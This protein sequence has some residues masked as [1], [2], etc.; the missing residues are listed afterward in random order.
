MKGKKNVAAILIAC[1]LLTMSSAVLGEETESSEK[2][3][4]LK[5]EQISSGITHT[6]KEI[7]NFGGTAGK[8]QRVNVLEADLTN[9]NVSIVTSK[10]LERVVAA[11]PLPSQ[12]ARE[13]FKGKDIVAGVNADM[14]NMQTGI[15]MTLQVQNRNLLIN[16]SY[17][18]GVSHH[19]VFAIDQDKKPF[20]GEVEMRGS[21]TYSGKNVKIDTLNRSENAGEKLGIFTPKLNQK[22]VLTFDDR[23]ETFI[24][25][26][27]MAVVKKVQ[28]ASA[29]KAGQAYSGKIE[30]IY[31]SYESIDIPS[32]SVI[33]TGFGSK[34]EIIRNELK[35][36]ME[37][38]FQFDL[39]TGQDR[40]LKNDITE[41]TGGYNWLVKDGKALS[42]DELES[43]YG[44]HVLLKS[45]RTA[46][47]ITAEQ[48]VITMTIDKPSTLFDK[49][50]GVTLVEM[51]EIMEEHGAVSALGL[52][53]GGSTEM[54]VQPK[55][56]SAL[57]TA[58]H[59]SDGQSRSITNGILFVNHSSK[60]DD[61]GEVIVEK[62]LTIFKN[63][64]FPFGVK[65]TDSNGNPVMIASRSIKWEASKGTI[66][67]TGLYKAPDQE[68]TDKVQ[69]VINGVSGGASVTVID[70]VD[71]FQFT[72][73]GPI[74]LQPGEEGKLDAEAV[75]DGK[76]VILSGDAIDWEMDQQYGE[77]T[78]DG[79]IQVRED[80]PEG[81]RTTVT[82]KLGSLERQV[83]LLIGLKEQVLDDYE[84][85]PTE[86]YGVTGFMGGTHQLSNEQAKFG[87][88]SLRIDYDS[89]KW[90]RKYN[91]TI[92]VVPHW[93]KSA[94][95]AWSDELADSMYETYKTDIRPKKFGMWVYGD[96][97][98][99]WARLIFKAN[100]VNKTLD[101]APKVD[102]IGWKYLEV[103]LP[104]DWELPIVFN[105]LYFVETSKSIPDYSGSVYLDH[106]R[107]IYSN[108]TEDFNGPEFKEITP[109]GNTVYENKIDFS[110]LLIDEESGVDAE[111]I[112]VKINGEKIPH[113]YDTDTGRVEAAA[114]NLAEGTYH[115]TASARDTNGNLSVPSV[116]KRIEVD[117]SEDN[118]KPV[119]SNVTP[120][121]KAVEKTAEPRITFKLKD[122][123]S[124]VKKSSIAVKIDGRQAPV[125]YD[126][127]SG[128][129]YAVPEKPLKDGQ[130]SFI[131]EAKDKSGNVMTPYVKHFDTKQ[132]QQPKKANQFAISILPDTQGFMYSKRL[133]DRAAKEETDFVM[134]V[135]DMV[136]TSSQSE[137]DRAG[138]DLAL[139]GDKPFFA[140]P[141]NHESFQGNI[142]FYSAIVGSPTYH[143]EYGNTLIISLNSAFGQSISASDPTQFHYL[144]KLLKENKKKNVL[145]V[146]H[147][148]TK[149]DF[150]TK[151]EMNPA[152]AKQFEDILGS[153][154][155]KNKNVNI[156]VLFGH[157]HLLQTWEVDGVNYTIT[158]NGASKGY[159]SNDKGNILGSGILAVTKAGMDYRFNP[160][161]TDVSIIDDALNEKREMKMAAGAKRTLNLFGDFR[162]ISGNYLVNLSSFEE[163]HTV[164]TSDNEKAVKVLADGTIQTIKPGKAN[165]T[166][167]SGGKSS[168]IKVT[169][170]DSLNIKP[171]NVELSPNNEAVI[172]G[173]NIRLTATAIDK[174]GNRFAMD[175]DKLFMELTPPD[176]AE[177]KKGKIKTKKSGTLTISYQYLEIKKSLE[178][179]ILPK[180][181]K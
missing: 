72:D 5:T 130:H 59:P 49:S 111:S 132:L 31:S 35:E 174:D 171:V 113:T 69:A 7:V 1:T 145:V 46:I 32:D 62:D 33:I 90:E 34:A 91:G 175:P 78:A 143:F 160:L 11:E 38:S 120:A 52:D 157:L 4:V 87:E 149:D 61:I 100:N 77:I 151:H 150:G 161:L 68:G 83:E 105:Y 92:N 153:Y 65:A 138:S 102:W 134:H 51:A 42:K 99:P 23:N 27:A 104:Q 110:S 28:D 101:L 8:S 43:K 176:L 66:D 103:E 97:K 54:I 70:Q 84:T 36:G 180:K 22:G 20:I 147:N 73:K 30:K 81:T 6:E 94:S 106:M 170:V 162:E 48:K 117:L 24:K 129:A 50:Q 109:A 88:S 53:G 181:Q 126:E 58:N 178:I 37:I 57:E 39:F 179:E 71:D 158:G 142:D 89:K 16:H 148:T 128:W 140:T 56:K 144:Q 172:E 116:D 67:K 167:V 141:G 146:T 64:S 107:Y 169:V 18:S 95:G 119:L 154:K 136:D 74:I 166:A 82:A 76:D 60:T 98:A 85:F 3:R 17:P 96:G 155:K 21:L 55:G 44:S 80:V 108:E 133:F 40:V 173:K 10:A 118:E 79:T 139:L 125:H 15:N 29:I 165:I 25:N 19:P 45:A 93:Y 121:G 12:A 86:G 114:D 135:G 47:G 131:I 26:G 13:E 9:P 137:W 122:E 164:W 156:Q 163:V 124:G 112:E 123:K 127:K 115:L 2:I 41:A 152:D 177:W 159:V 63:A 168:T 75:K 14:F